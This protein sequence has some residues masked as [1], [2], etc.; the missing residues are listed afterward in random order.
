[1]GSRQTQ[2]RQDVT[3]PYLSDI[4][5]LQIALDL[6]RQDL[7]LAKAIKARLEDELGCSTCDQC[8][9][10][11]K[12]SAKQEAERN[13]KT[14]LLHGQLSDSERE[15]EDLKAKLKSLGEP[16]TQHGNY[17]AGHIAEYEARLAELEEQLNSLKSVQTLGQETPEG[18][19]IESQ[20]QQERKLRKQV[21]E[22]MQRQVQEMFE[23]SGQLEGVVEKKRKFEEKISE[24]ELE[25]ANLAELL[26]SMLK[27]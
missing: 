12:T 15:A 10:Q 6:S 21:E 17:R 13:E 1:M 8:K 14:R 25:K 26:D 2:P 23:L 9:E 18:S 16:E 27:E 11:E 5:S 4:K 7:Q 20:L 22:E 19:E 3:L 24:V